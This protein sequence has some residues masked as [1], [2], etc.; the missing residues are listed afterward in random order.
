MLH[1]PCTACI[2]VSARVQLPYL[3]I[4]DYSS[5][6]GRVTDEAGQNSMNTQCAKLRFDCATGL[7]EH[8]EEVQRTAGFGAAGSET[9]A[10][11]EA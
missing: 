4:W 8:L 5:R 2:Q 3:S 9:D 1:I 7:R 10:E 6:S 11:G